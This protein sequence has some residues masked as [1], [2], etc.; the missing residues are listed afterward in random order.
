VLIISGGWLPRRSIRTP[1]HLR[2]RRRFDCWRTPP[3]VMTNLAAD[4][5]CGASDLVC[6]YRKP[7]SVFTVRSRPCG[8][9]ELLGPDG[10][11]GLGQEILVEPSRP[12]DQ[13]FRPSLS[14][15]VRDTGRHG[16][17]QPI[18]DMDSEIASM[19]IK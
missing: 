6:I 1:G 16:F 5:H 4:L 19:P 2:V 13:R 18:G 9:F 8:Y 15:R 11:S 14:A 12:V 17:R 10:Q 7:S 3:L